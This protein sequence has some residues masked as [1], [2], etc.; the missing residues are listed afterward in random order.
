MNVETSPRWAKRALV[1]TLAHARCRPNG[2]LT[3]GLRQVRDSRGP[4]Q[5]IVIDR[6]IA[7]RQSPDQTPIISASLAIVWD[8]QHRLADMA[9]RSWSVCHGMP[10][11][12]DFSA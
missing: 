3:G 9:G 11:R 1:K 7:C 2:W 8:D 6:D 5:H 12:V 10:Y 4:V